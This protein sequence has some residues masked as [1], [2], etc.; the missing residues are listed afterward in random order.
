MVY[1]CIK[2]N[3]VLKGTAPTGLVVSQHLSTGTYLFYNCL[4]TNPNVST[5]PSCGHYE[6]V[7]VSL[8]KYL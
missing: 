4:E 7:I 6:I 8:L 3:I 2:N 5:I 1:I